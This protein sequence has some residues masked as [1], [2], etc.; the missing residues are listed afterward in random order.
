MMAGFLG[1]VPFHDLT[2]LPKDIEWKYLGNVDLDNI[3]KVIEKYELIWLEKTDAAHITYNKWIFLV[4][5][6]TNRPMKTEFHRKLE[7]DTEYNLESVIEVKYLSDYE[8]RSKIKGV[9]P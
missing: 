6:E 1:L 9:F 3:T 8:M 7:G 2:L 5:L 4:D